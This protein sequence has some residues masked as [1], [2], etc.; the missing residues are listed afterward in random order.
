M[1]ASDPTLSSSSTSL[2]DSINAV[3]PGASPSATAM[4]GNSDN[5][6]N[7][8]APRFKD[9]S[10][11]LSYYRRAKTADEPSSKNR[12]L[13]QALV[14]GE[15]PYKAAALRTAG[16]PGATNINFLEGAALVDATTTAY[17]ALIDGVD[18][19]V[20]G[21]MQP[22]V[23]DPTEAVEYA[24]G[25]AEEISSLIREAP[26]FSFSWEY[27]SR[28]IATHGAAVAFFP[29]DDGVEWIAGGLDDFVIPRQ[30]R[31]TEEAVEV[32]FALRKTQLHELWIKI[33]NE[34]VAT[35]LGWNVAVAKE[36]LVKAASGISSRT[37]WANGWAD[38]Q[39]RLKNND[40]G[41][42][43]DAATI[44]VVHAWVRERSGKISHYMF[45]ADGTGGANF[46][47]SK[48]DR[49]SPVTDAF[50]I[51]TAGIGSNGTYHSIRGAAYRAYN[52]LSESNKL[53]CSMLDG[54]KLAIAT[55][56]RPKD[57][58]SLD[59][60]TITV[61]GVTAYLPPD[62]EIAERGQMPSPAQHILPI[63]SDLSQILSNTTG[64]YRPRPNATEGPEK[65]RLEIQ[66]QIESTTALTTS[67]VNVFYRS[68]DRF[69]NSILR[70]VQRLDPEQ[71]AITGDHPAVL[72]FYNRVVARGIPVQA[73]KAIRKLIP[74]KALGLGSPTQRLAAINAISQ[75]AG[76]FDEV[77]RRTFDR[78]LL[79]ASV[80]SDQVDALL[81]KNPT[82]RTTVDNKIA[83][84]EHANMR[85]SDT[86]I[87]PSELQSTHIQ[88]HLGKL[89]QDF[90]VIQQAV[91][92]QDQQD[93]SPE[94]NIKNVQYLMRVIQHTS[95]HI[96]Q[97]RNDQTRVQEVAQYDNLLGQF[98]AA[99]KRLADQVSA[100]MQNKQA[101]Q[102]PTM[103]P[104]MQAKMQSHQLDMQMA[105][106]DH[107]QKMQMKAAEFQQRMKL[108]SIQTDQRLSSQITQANLKRF[109]P[110]AVPVPAYRQ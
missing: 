39:S 35:D 2:T 31:A 85:F 13:V 25:I 38:V 105:K 95:A 102:G 104:E 99:V 69:T 109:G 3:A 96:D 19:L 40:F 91:N 1:N 61:N 46:L 70:R 75:L 36:A 44:P 45:L 24:S 28:Q 59:D 26:E 33:E 56:V 76:G 47:F 108:R 50:V 94:D 74:V 14:D 73:V 6:A 90:P 42:S 106:E 43:N 9:A 57:G 79:A 27:I 88:I 16:R 58:E 107:D 41:L 48:R 10:E 20:R 5:A 60:M 78:M 63:V 30:T 51:F 62:A 98:S 21:V 65:S 11:A 97:L 92:G 4:S 12:A 103:T 34:Q 22:G 81:P 7:P 83:E 49:F 86:P 68:L 100:G 53:R 55:L 64:M 89:Q 110:A 87:D 17:N 77:G 66:A 71:L 101:A 67:S 15:P 18:T 54:T 8:A 23:F 52:V 37:G 80:G 93:G 29:E 82:A 84:L 72:D 32:L